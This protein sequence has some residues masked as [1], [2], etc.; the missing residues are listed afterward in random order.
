MKLFIYTIFICMI[1]S[2]TES[3]E[4][5]MALQHAVTVM[6][7]S[8]D[9][10]LH[11]L[12]S[13]KE[14][15]QQFGK[16]FRMQCRL[17]RI[18][19]L[20]KLDTLF[21]N[22]DETQLLADYFDEH[23]TANEKMLAH[24]L[25]GR[26]YYDTGESPMALRCFQD[27]VSKA[28]TTDAGCD[29]AQLS[30]VYG[31]M[32]NLF[33]QQN[34]I[35]ND[36]ECTDKAIKYA[37]MAGDTINAL[38]NMAEK[39]EIYDE[40]NKPDSTIFLCKKLFLHFKKYGYADIAAS[41]LGASIDALLDRGDIT[42]AK[43]YID[44]YDAESGFFDVNGNI[45]P[46]REVYYY[47]KG[48]YNLAINKYD[49]AEYYFRKELRDGKDFNNQNMGS[50]GLAQLFQHINRPDSAAKYALYSYEMNDSVYARM[51]TKEV[52]NI[53]GLYNYIHNQEI[54]QKEKEKTATEHNKVRWLACSL[55]IIMLSGIYYIRNTR[56]K[57][58]EMSLQYHKSITNI[59]YLQS[60]ITKLTSQKSD[61]DKLLANE[62]S[63][64]LEKSHI[65]EDNTL[66][67]RQAL[68]GMDLL[69]HNIEELHQMITEKENIIK[70]LK[71]DLQVKY[72]QEKQEIDLANENLKHHR[73]YPTLQDLSSKGN[74]PDN[75]QW[76]E[77]KTMTAEIYPA[78]YEFISS[79]NLNEKELYT[80]LL[81]RMFVNPKVIS[82]MLGVTPA[83]ISKIRSKMLLSLFNV[84]GTAKEFDKKI[85]NMI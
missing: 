75:C 17:H 66:A 46:G 52:E 35:N 84:T 79:K 65:L 20:N 58:K 48:R 53:H 47:S 30:R 62:R 27:A 7:G 42:K 54:A 32:G 21:T 43:H 25:L 63:K 44:I 1:L 67:L 5:R 2:C 37:W 74:T 12:D 78:F 26:A 15:E 13:L 76:Q 61:L 82:Y 16:H 38:L 29:Y 73:F 80:C 6:N 69:N 8:P 31:Q 34:L 39:I 9:S 83:Y 85:M 71:M 36:L 22:T 4:H 49:S 33:W 45:E 68:S 59:A 28:D 57:R 50:R 23:G 70:K 64:H 14:N 55:F 10:A 11:I 56:K 51:A 3:R 60:E 81:L 40:W 72:K 18:N 24:Y 41:M 77:I 19:A